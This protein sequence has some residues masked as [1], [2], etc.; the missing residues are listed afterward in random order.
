MS[1]IQEDAPVQPAAD[2]FDPTKTH[3]ITVYNVRIIKTTKYFTNCS[4]N[5]STLNKT[6]F[7]V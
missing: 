4:E 5:K 7:L 6:I 2:S 1:D 3:G